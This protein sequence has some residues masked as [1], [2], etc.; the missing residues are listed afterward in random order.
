M[1]VLKDEHK[2]GIEYTI[3]HTSITA[4]RIIK[5]SQYVETLVNVLT[6]DAG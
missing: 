6:P 3:T 5:Q 1:S 4:Y 2:W